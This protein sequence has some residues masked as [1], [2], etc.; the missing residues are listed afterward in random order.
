[1]MKS[2]KIILPLFL[3]LWSAKILRA[4]DNTYAEVVTSNGVLLHDKISLNELHDVN[5]LNVYKTEGNQVKKIP[6]VSF[7]ITLIER[8][9]EPREF[10]CNSEILP[11]NV[12]EALKEINGG[13]KIY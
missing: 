10:D 6:V 3:L 2:F 13:A 7:K 9:K 12:K 4:Q 11:S 5:A 1:M 8:K